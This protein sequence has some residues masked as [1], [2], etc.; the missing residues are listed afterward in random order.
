LCKILYSN[1]RKPEERQIT[2]SNQRAYA[3]VSTYLNGI[4]DRKP[5][6]PA[7]AGMTSKSTQRSK[8]GVIPAQA[9]I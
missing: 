2:K 3:F 7:F 1:I 9:G 4:A 5:G 6:I 8:N